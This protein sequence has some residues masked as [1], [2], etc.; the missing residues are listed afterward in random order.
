L[1][2][3]AAV[4]FRDVI[5]PLGQANKELR[6]SFFFF[7]FL[8]LSRSDLIR[9]LN[10]FFTAIGSVSCVGM[11]GATLGGGVGRYNGL[12]GMILDS[13]QSVRVVTAAGQII[14]ASTTENSDLFWGIR[15]AGFNYVTVL[16]AT[17]SIYNE[18]APL[19]LN[20]DFLFA[21][22][23]SESILRYFKSFED[24]GGLPAKL[25]LVLLAAY[26][27]ELGGVSL[28]L[29]L[30]TSILTLTNVCVSIQKV[31]H[32]RQ[33]SLRRPP[34]RSRAIPPTSI[35]RLPNTIQPE[36]DPL[37][38]NQRRFTLCRRACQLHLSDK[39]AAKRLW[40]RRP[41]VRCTNLPNLLQQLQRAHFL[42]ARPAKRNSLH[43][44]VLCQAGG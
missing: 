19:V 39:L 20:A 1:T 16:E 21:S 38:S 29:T 40:R 25:A 34:S 13:L 10:F 26:S 4:R 17:Y 35:R 7:F 33:C 36:H 8:T 14:T 9:I 23:A 42:H 27:A 6:K 5:G 12:H 41:S 22:N 32:H 11:I 44:R 18:T 28:H 15:G 43:R 30:Y 3:G 24:N 37:V 2:I 31:I